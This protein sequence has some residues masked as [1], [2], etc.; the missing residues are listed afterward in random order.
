MTRLCCKSSA[1]SVSVYRLSRTRYIVEYD[2]ENMHHT[3][4]ADADNVV[5]AS[6]VEFD[7]T[8]GEL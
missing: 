1:I 7:S 4:N 6:W 3:P 8:M 2:G 5:R